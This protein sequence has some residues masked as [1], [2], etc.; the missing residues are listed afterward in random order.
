MNDTDDGL[1][2]EDAILNNTV[3]LQAANVAWLMFQQTGMP[4]MYMLYTDLLEPQHRERSI[5]D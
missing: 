5:L 1:I 4:G 2:G 3:G